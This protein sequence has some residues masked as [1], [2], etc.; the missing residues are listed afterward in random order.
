MNNKTRVLRLLQYL[1]ENT[2]EGTAVTNSDIRAWF[3]SLGENTSLPTIRDDIACL[4]ESGYDIDVREVNG[5]ATYYKYLDR[6]WTAAELQILVDAVSAGQFLS[7][8]K[9]EKLIAKLRAMA[10]PTERSQIEPG[11][12]VEKQVKAPNEQILYIVQAIR[13]AILKD[14][15]IS[16]RHYEYTPDKQRIPKHAGYQYTVSPYAMIWKKDRYYLIGWS[17]KHGSVAHFRIDRMGLPKEVHKPRRPAP[18]D[19]R[20]EDRTDRIFSMFDGPEETVT[21]RLRPY[22]V[23]NLIDQFG[24]NVRITDVKE[25]HVE[26]VATVHLSPTF[27]GWLFQY[28]GQMTVTAPEYVCEQYAAQMQLGIDDVLGN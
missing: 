9:T 28:V 10:G 8:D 5:V 25:Y 13:D 6:Q 4:R 16:F 26:A 3:R 7:P 23:T 27:Y 14:E 17:E 24:E 15:Q 2:D 21:F 12:L 22:L 19:L 11:I 20:L 1:A 18:E